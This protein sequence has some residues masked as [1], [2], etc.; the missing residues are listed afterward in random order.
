LGIPVEP[1]SEYK[2]TALTLANSPISSGRSTPAL[3]PAPFKQL[4]GRGRKGKLP[5]IV[6]LDNLGNTCYMNSALQCVRSI[7]EL[8][9]YFLSKSSPTLAFY[10]IKVTRR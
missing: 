5:R 4:F 7:E 9:Y 1:K 6:G 3:G 2:S 10:E 8:T